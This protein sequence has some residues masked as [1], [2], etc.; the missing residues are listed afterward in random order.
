MP[1]VV[2]EDGTVTV[3]GEEAQT[4]INGLQQQISSTPVSQSISN[5]QIQNVVTASAEQTQVDVDG[6]QINIQS[7][8]NQ[9]LDDTFIINHAS[10]KNLT[11]DDHPQYHND[12]RGDLRY[13]PLS[14]LSGGNNPHSL[15][16]ASLP[17]LSN[18]GLRITKADR[19]FILANIDNDS[20]P[21]TQIESIVAGKIAAGIIAAKVI[22]ADVFTSSNQGGVLNDD[23]ANL[24]LGDDRIQLGYVADALKTY[25]LRHTNGYADN[26]PNYRSY[27]SIDSAGNVSVEGNI[28]ISGGSGV[29][30]LSDSGALALRDKTT[31]YSNTE[32][33]A[34]DSIIGDIWFDTS[35]GNDP[36]RFNGS[37]YVSV[38]DSDVA[39]AQGTADGKT[40]SYFSDTAPT[41]NGKGVALSAAD[42]GDL[43]FDTDNGLRAYYYDD[44][45][46]AKWID[47][48]DSDIA[49]GIAAASTAQATADGKVTTYTGTEP[50]PVDLGDLW[51]DIANR[52][53]KR[54][55]ISG[56]L[57]IKEEVGAWL[58]DSTTETIT[59]PDTD[60]DLSATAHD[61]DLAGTLD[62]AP[63]VV[64]STTVK[65]SGFSVANYFSQTYESSL[66]FGTGDFSIFGW[67]IQDPNTAVE[68]IFSRGNWTGSAW[69]G[70]VI[71][72]RVTASGFLEISI[73]DDGETTTD[74]ITSVTTID[75]G[76]PHLFLINR[77]DNEISIYLDGAITP[78][79]SGTLVNATGNLSNASAIV[80]IGRSVDGTLPLLNG[81]LSILKIVP[82]F[83]TDAEIQEL[84]ELEKGLFGYDITT[85]VWETVSNS[86]GT[87]GL[88]VD[89]ANLGKKADWDQVADPVGTKP[90]DNAD[91]TN[92]GSANYVLRGLGSPNSSTGSV[93]TAT[94][95]AGD[96]SFTLPDSSGVTQLVTFDLP[97]LEVNTD[98]VLSLWAY[99]SVDGTEFDVELTPSGLPDFYQAVTTTATKYSW[100]FNSSDANMSV[101]DLLIFKTAVRT[102]PTATVTVYDVKFEKGT[103]PTDWTPYNPIVD[104]A[105]DTKTTMENS[106]SISTGGVVLTGS[107]TFEFS[108]GGNIH[109]ANKTSYADTDAGIFLGWDTTET[110]YVL[111]IGD[112]TNHIKWDGT[113]LTMT[114][115]MTISNPGDIN[116]LDLLNGPAQANADVTGSN[117]AADTALVAGTAA[118]T[119]RDNAA[120]ALSNA[121][122]AQS[123]ADGKITSFYQTTAP[124]AGMGEG[125]IWFDTDD[126]NKVYI[127]ESS[128]W[129]NRQDSDI[130]TAISDAATAQ[131]TAD[132]KVTTFFTTSTPTADAVGD[133]W[134]SS[135]TNLFKRWD[136]VDWDD[137][138]NL[139]ALNLVNAPTEAGA[140]STGTR[141]E[142][143]T[144]IT[145][146]GITLSSGGSIK[147]GQTAFDTGTGFFFGYESGA[148]K[149]SIGNPAAN[150]L[151]W[152]GTVLDIVGEIHLD[153]HLEAG[154]TITS[155]GVTLNAGGSFKSTGLTNENVDAT[156][157]VWLGY[158]STSTK[159]TFGVGD[160]AD[161]FIKFDG[162]DL[163]LGRDVKISGVEAFFNDSIYWT[164]YFDTIDAYELGGSPT[165]DWRGL[166]VT[167]TTSSSAGAKR[168]LNNPNIQWNADRIFIADLYIGDLS[169]STGE[170][171]M[172]TGDAGGFD[173]GFGF[174]FE[175]DSV[176]SK[177]KAY[178]ITSN[179]S[180]ETSSYIASYDEGTSFVLT[181]NF[182][183]GTNVVFTI[184]TS[185]TSDNVTVT[186]NLPSGGKAASTNAPYIFWFDVPIT[187]TGTILAICSRYKF[188]QDE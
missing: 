60:T 41:L 156:A 70:S 158:N 24:A 23:E 67:I 84:Y 53:L 149:L 123:T 97:A 181:A 180:G 102:N 100:V 105:D 167:S 43:W 20:I 135:S 137:D 56:S 26:N 155:G 138:I 46:P 2:N 159:Y 69:S 147:G 178:G 68:T 133:L 127:Y 58:V 93:T 106:V 183:S 16:A 76:N 85:P 18:W 52:V 13:V 61:L 59:S 51:F 12:A 117:T 29:A 140:D 114:G 17:G 28:T 124:V 3:T 131:S 168:Y 94:E 164:T 4:I 187:T 122:T 27:F 125:D 166:V 54:S 25:M 175:W 179:S 19:D 80:N 78:D 22:L 73:S 34:Q 72:I 32:P 36:Y 5:D 162:T 161:K 150:N 120:N 64:D 66:D 111:N 77:K 6:V 126:G 33:A 103:Q 104:K 145:S 57:L 86:F 132:G 110:D 119:V 134:F 47:A 139:D 99:S 160:G 109:S 136:G 184:K 169:N 115:S 74:I 154:T 170:V 50:N 21:S 96:W 10:T 143:G 130:A 15:D 42:N 121:A 152:N 62:K 141:L 8:A 35:N 142:A 40:A 116:A 88:L 11:S 38:K 83:S 90:Q 49:A 108:S 75:N 79:N 128:S 55:T 1:I 14:H 157:G 129:V 112:A 44:S 176:T 39:I 30:N 173:T 48:Q 82:R 81:A 71:E 165:A 144:T 87:T 151:T 172:Q 65:Y 113:N 45:D 91:V 37:S 188:W 171:Y 118:A 95:G 92:I 163:S 174:K 89:T 9:V 63:A 177:I 7:I 101:A 185:T 98:Y 31:F 146:G 107:A 148:Y 182:T 153:T 186:T